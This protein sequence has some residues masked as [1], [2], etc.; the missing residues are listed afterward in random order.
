MNEAT[1]TQ[2]YN[3]CDSFAFPCPRCQAKIAIRE[4]LEGE[5]RPECLGND[6]GV[7]CGSPSEFGIVPRVPGPTVS[8]L[9]ALYSC[10]VGGSTCGRRHEAVD[11]SMEVNY[12]SRS[13]F[14]C[15]ETVCGHRTRVQAFGWSR[16]G[17][18]CPKCHTG[19]MRK[20]YTTRMLY[21]QQCFLRQALDVRACVEEL[22]TEEQKS[23]NFS[24]LRT[25]CREHPD[26]VLL[27]SS[28]PRLRESPG[29]VQGLHREERF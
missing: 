2:D 6:R 27:R 13:I 23:K 19:V 4:A 5:V 18:M 12:I 15:D 14:R 25:I 9:L 20:E 1:W 7:G 24:L 26:S 29:V 16:E 3:A 22:K 11:M 28:R 17:V 10:Q 21:D 8:S